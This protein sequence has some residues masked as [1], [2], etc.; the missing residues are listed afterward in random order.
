MPREVNDTQSYFDKAVKLV[1][2]EIVG[3]YMVLAGIIGADAASTA[4]PTDSLSKILLTVVF[5][6]LLILTP[7]YLIFISKVKN[8]VQIVITTLA[9]ILWI[10][11][12]GGPFSIWGIYN[13]KIA[14]V[15][16]TVWSLVMP[17][18]VRPDPATQSGTT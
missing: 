14:A 5:F 9:Y 6:V 8:K 11:T 4:A 2:T 3:A 15:L 12:L 16:L 18:V 7:L 10:Y 13:A 1:P 17:L